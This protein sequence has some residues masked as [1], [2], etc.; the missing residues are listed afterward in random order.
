MLQVSYTKDLWTRK[1]FGWMR[2]YEVRSEQ[3][4]EF[5]HYIIIFSSVSLCKCKC[6]F[7]VLFHFLG[8]K[9]REGRTDVIIVLLLA[10]NMYVCIDERGNCR[11][12]ELAGVTFFYLT[13]HH[14]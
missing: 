4:E 6:F 7:L 3:E 10:S 2:D 13:Y 1:I 12:V 9:S 5:C 8:K 11:V 14:D